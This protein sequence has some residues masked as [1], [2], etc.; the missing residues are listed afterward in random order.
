MTDPEPAVI[1]V[2][3]GGTLTGA[4]RV[5]GSDAPLAGAVL[6]L[7][8][9]NGAVVDLGNYRN[10]R[11]T[12]V[13]AAVTGEDGSYAFSELG[14]GECLVVPMPA[15]VR[16]RWPI[17]LEVGSSLPVALASNETRVVNF[18]AREPIEEDETDE[19]NDWTVRADLVAYRFQPWHFVTNEVEALC[20]RILAPRT[21]LEWEINRLFGT[22]N[23]D[24]LGTGDGPCQRQGL[25]NGFIRTA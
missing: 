14:S 8:D 1:P 22:N 18:R 7:V 10:H 9:T 24:A 12:L 11:R 5:Q 17:A 4:V 25:A 2:A 23:L 6:W 16:E 3:K 15:G 20:G 21:R 13:A 19:C